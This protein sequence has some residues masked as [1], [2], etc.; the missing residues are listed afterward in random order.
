MTSRKEQI[1]KSV[2]EIAEFLFSG[3]FHYDSNTSW[4]PR[5]SIQEAI[6]VGELSS[7]DL[8]RWFSDKV[9]EILLSDDDNFK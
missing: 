3:E 6:R 2:E 8:V 1:Q 9:C 7:I 4:L 5:G